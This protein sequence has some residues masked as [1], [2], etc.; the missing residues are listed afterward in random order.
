MQLTKEGGRRALGRGGRSGKVHALSY[1][2]VV[3]TTVSNCP[4]L[5]VQGHYVLSKLSQLDPPQVVDT[6]PT[7]QVFW[8]FELLVV[9][10][11]CL[12]RWAPRAPG[13]VHCAGAPH[14]VELIHADDLGV[15]SRGG[16]VH[17]LRHTSKGTC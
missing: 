14:G 5:P 7:H 9:Q 8:D 6:T 2:P 16:V 13:A 12:D 10:Q 17:S 4:T 15:L 11:Q 1:T 3:Y